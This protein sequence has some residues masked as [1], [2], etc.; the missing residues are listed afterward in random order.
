MSI[1]DVLNFMDSC[2]KEDLYKIRRESHKRIAK[3]NDTKPKQ[4][5]QWAM[6]IAQEIYAHALKNFPFLGEPDLNSWAMDIDKLNRI[7]GVS[8]VDIR[9]LVEYAYT[10]DFWSNQI[11]LLQKSSV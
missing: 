11:R 9:N 5:P 1:T 8:Q 4:A 10:D 3:V 2:S 7:D 6:D